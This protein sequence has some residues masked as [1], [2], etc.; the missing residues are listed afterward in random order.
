MKVVIQLPS[1]PH[2]RVPVFRLLAQRPGIE[3]H[4][5]HGFLVELPTDEAGGFSESIDQ[6]YKLPVPWKYWWSRGQIRYATRK[7]TDVLVL[8]WN[9]RFLSSVPAL[10]RARLHRVPTVLWGHGYSKSDTRVRR[11]FRNAVGRMAS[12]VVVYDP[13]T[14]RRIVDGDGFDGSRVFVAHNTID[15]ERILRYRVEL[16]SDERRIATFRSEHNL[17]DP[18]VLFVSRLLKSNRVDVLIEAVSRLRERGIGVSCAIV[19]SGPDLLRLKQLAKRLRVDRHVVFEPATYVEATLAQWFMSAT[20]F[21]YPSNAGLS[22]NHAMAYGLP[23]LVGDNLRRHNPEIH[24]VIEEQNGL[25]FRQNDPAALERAI[26]R[27]VTD[28]GLLQ[29]LQLGA[30]ETASELMLDKMVDGL[31][32]AIRGAMSSRTKTP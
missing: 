27:I 6:N 22:L 21:C 8:T 11:A 24:W 1:L 17:R 29:R 5:T 3:L 10:L 9:I 7:R 25:L 19:G 14:A 4:V 20:A 13:V 12:T 32:A 31:E 26:E 28:E 2:Y 30:L 16:E 23:V 15:Q 18:T